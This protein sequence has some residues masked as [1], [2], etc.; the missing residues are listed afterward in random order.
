ME[1]R[2]LR[3]IRAKIK[4]FS[5]TALEGF[6]VFCFYPFLCLLPYGW[7][8]KVARWVGKLNFRMMHQLRESIL[9]E[10]AECLPERT[11]EERQEIARR[12]F[13]VRASFY[14]DSYMVLKHRIKTW[15]KKFINIEGAEHVEASLKKGKGAILCSMH[16]NHYFLPLALLGKRFPTTGYGVW[17][18]DLRKVNV[19]VKLHHRLLIWAGRRKS[20]SQ[21]LAAG[22][23]PKGALEG[24]LRENR[25]LFI[26]FDIPLPE[27][28]DLRP[29]KFFGQ[30]VL[31]PWGLIMVKYLTQAAF[32]IGYV[33]RDLAD[34]EKQTL[35]ITPELTFSGKLAE[36]QQTVA[37]ELEKAIRRYPEFWWGWGVILT[38]RPD[39]IK[40]ARRRGDY[41]T[42]ILGK[43]KERP[44]GVPEV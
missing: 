27:M 31:F 17:P 36:D 4:R 12:A 5:R 18:S 35:I 11:E 21:F 13:E 7:G 6:S 25:V 37:S 19:F 22:R 33:V 3:Q 8:Y 15:T 10:L 44:Q 42:S 2:M 39:F 41:T 32:H 34:W 43:D 24:V 30:E 1:M 38:M 20:G 16:F 40:E 14:C 9:K 29:V 23:H 26:L 28:R